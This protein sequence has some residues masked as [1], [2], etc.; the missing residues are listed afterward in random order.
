MRMILFSLPILL[1]VTMARLEW[2]V[3]KSMKNELKIT[4]KARKDLILSRS[5]Y[6]S[7]QEDNICDSKTSLEDL[8][9]K[10]KISPNVNRVKQ[11]SHNSSHMLHT[12]GS[13]WV[14]NRY[15]YTRYD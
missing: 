7:L 14:R 2:K 9:D 10:I 3:S 11:C 8:R 6:T 12:S 5:A 15:L 1:S 13:T 4:E